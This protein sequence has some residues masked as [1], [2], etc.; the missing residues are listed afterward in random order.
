MAS[1][2]ESK[3]MGTDAMQHPWDKE[4]RFA[5]TPFSLTSRVLGKVQRKMIDHSDT[6]MANPAFV[7]SAFNLLSANHIVIADELFVC[8]IIF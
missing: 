5:F 7:F 8:L 3:S 6:N 4:F 2:L 1:K